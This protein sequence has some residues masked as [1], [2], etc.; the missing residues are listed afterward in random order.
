MSSIAA[1][2]MN[3]PWQIYCKGVRLFGFV[4]GNQSHAVKA[5]DPAMQ[6]KS[7]CVKKNITRF[8]LILTVLFCQV[9]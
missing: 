2:N 8:N 9:C 6:L 5:E 4:A 3:L 7:E 1:K